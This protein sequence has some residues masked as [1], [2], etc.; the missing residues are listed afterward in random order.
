MTDTLAPIDDKENSDI[1]LYK[2][3]S[4][5]VFLRRFVFWFFPSLSNKGV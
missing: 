2:G 5:R 1:I 4:S 3:V